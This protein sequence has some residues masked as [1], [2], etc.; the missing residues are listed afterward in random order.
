MEIVQVQTRTGMWPWCMGTFGARF[1]VFVRRA[2]VLPSP[3]TCLA[4]ALQCLCDRRAC[5]PAP[6]MQLV[7]CR[8]LGF[9]F[10]NMIILVTKTF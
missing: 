5:C 3:A 6:A 8:S 2:R 7:N 10:E 1:A 4:H 9:T